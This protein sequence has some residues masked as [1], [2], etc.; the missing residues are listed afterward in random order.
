MEE[1]NTHT[2]NANSKTAFISEV[3]YIITALLPPLGLP[4]LGWYYL[5]H[6]HDNNPLTRAHLKQTIIA[7]GLIS[8]L[9]LFTN[10]LVIYFGGY[11]SISA[12]IIFELY[13]FFSYPYICHSRY[14]GGS[15]SQLRRN[16]PV[17]VDSQ[18]SG[19]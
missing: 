14:C 11:R 1:A 6:R 2:H 3:L 15:K 18:I 13:F 17:P 4:F 9:L 8:F 7:G 5:S 19:H 16:F 12:L 10:S